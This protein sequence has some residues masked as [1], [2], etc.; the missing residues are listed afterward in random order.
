MVWFGFGDPSVLIAC[1]S[2]TKSYS[3]SL[4]CCRYLLFSTGPGRCCSS[5]A[6]EWNGI[7]TDWQKRVMRYKVSGAHCNNIGK[8]LYERESIETV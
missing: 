3:G 1:L 4:G 7:T 8:N 5:D 2:E 6:N